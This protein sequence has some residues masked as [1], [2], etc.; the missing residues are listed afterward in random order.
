MLGVG[1]VW[2]VAVRLAV[3]GG[4]LGGVSLCCPFSAGYL[5]LDLGLNWVSF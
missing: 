4:V 2:G 5:G 3:T 1:P